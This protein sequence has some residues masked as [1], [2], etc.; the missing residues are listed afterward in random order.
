MPPGPA[1]DDEPINNGL[2][3]R[4]RATGDQLAAASHSRVTDDVILS[5]P[6]WP[7]SDGND[8]RCG[9]VFKIDGLQSDPLVITGLHELFPIM[10]T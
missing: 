4:V 8:L 9:G 3:Y 2:T 6:N 5:M 7:P 1:H 10:G